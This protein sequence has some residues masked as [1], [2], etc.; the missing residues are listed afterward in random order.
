MKMRMRPSF[1]S[2][3]LILLGVVLGIGLTV[4]I[5]IWL[6]QSGEEEHVPPRL[7]VEE[8]P[9]RAALAVANDTARS[10][11][12]MAGR[13]GNFVSAA[14]LAQAIRYS[15]GQARTG[16][17][18]PVPDYV[19]ERLAPY[20]PAR[21]LRNARWVLAGRR[22]SLGTVLAGWYYREGAVTLDD[23]IVFSST[24]AATHIGLWA[25]ELTHVRQYEELGVE[26]FARLYA[27]NWPALE[28]QA[29][30]NGRL[31]IADLAQRRN[32]T[33]TRQSAGAAAVVHSEA[34]PQPTDRR[35]AAVRTVRRASAA[36]T[37][38]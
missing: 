32:R 30:E 33:I 15:R 9:L 28:N 24:R 2:I 25:H 10:T 8:E 13:G 21:T 23:T 36:P 29:Q 37:R 6:S 1:K 3:V 26:D 7:R 18:S 14:A 16:M 5:G 34:R 35:K 38:A 11:A 20:F 12:T 19:R 31:I 4:A 22:V 27:T 17:T